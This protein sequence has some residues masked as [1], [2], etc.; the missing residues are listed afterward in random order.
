MK[1]RKK[2]PPSRNERF[3]STCGWC[4]K[5][6]PEDTEVFGAGARAHGNIDLTPHAGTV[7]EMALLSVDKT[8]LVAVT[9]LDSE[10]KRR[11]HDL[12]FMTCSDEC[13]EKLRRAVE[14][15]FNIVRT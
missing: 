7:I 2:R 3:Q 11:G 12:M 15:D 8:V 10:A 14:E 4:G 6:I 9:G 1:R 13:G 5:H